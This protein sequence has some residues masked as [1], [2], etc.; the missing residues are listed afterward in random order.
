[1]ADS[2]ESLYEDILDRASDAAGLAMW[3][4]QLDSGAMTFDQIE[5]SFYGSA[6]YQQLQASSAQSTSASTSATGAASSNGTSAAAG[7][8]SDPA[9]AGATNSQLADLGDSV[10]KFTKYDDLINSLSSSYTL[11]NSDSGLQDGYF[12][13]MPGAQVI[14]RKYGDN[15][16]GPGAG[17]DKPWE[18]KPGASDVEMLNMANPNK[19]GWNVMLSRGAD[20]SIV[21]KDYEQDGPWAGLV[22]LA[23]FAATAY[24]MSTGIGMLA[25]AG[26]GAAGVATATAPELSTVGELSLSDAMA[27]YAPDF[28]EQVGA[29]GMGDTAFATGLTEAVSPDLSSAFLKDFPGLNTLGSGMNGL[30]TVDSLLKVG[31]MGPGGTFNLGGMSLLPDGSLVGASDLFGAT[32]PWINPGTSTITDIVVNSAG[33]VSDLLA[34]VDPWSKYVA[35]MGDVLPPTGTNW[36]DKVVDTAKKATDG[37]TA[38]DV[39][40]TVGTIGTL[41]SLVKGINGTNGTNG[42]NAS[43]TTINFPEIKP[44]EPASGPLSLP[45]SQRAGVKF[46][47]P[48]SKRELRGKFSGTG[49]K[50]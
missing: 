31:T 29:A 21:R 23:K 20:G 42:I 9:A 35:G 41:T 6:E 32:A 43:G 34:G 48:K 38:K 19:E 17:M 24:L 10:S 8:Q 16:A 44:H 28:A 18:W 37:I 36:W 3:Q 4:Q 5:R 40:S 1:M 15:D 30:D 12:A 39:L 46:G 2:I 45:V 27:T 11:K 47:Q 33:S 49:L 25:D 22:D 26:A 50:I 13:S 14:F 7:V